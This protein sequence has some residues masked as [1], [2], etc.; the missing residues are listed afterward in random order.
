MHGDLHFEGL[1]VI[2]GTEKS[3]VVDVDQHD[4]WVSPI[5]M[6]DENQY[7]TRNVF[8]EAES[9]KCAMWHVGGYAIADL[10]VLSHITLS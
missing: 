9:F 8:L 10:P 6:L 2:Q 3:N 7:I 4:E 5:V 1:D